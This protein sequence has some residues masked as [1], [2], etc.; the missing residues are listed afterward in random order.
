MGVGIPHNVLSAV[1]GKI[2]NTSENRTSTVTSGRRDAEMH[3]VSLSDNLAAPEGT[4]AALSVPVEVP[5]PNPLIEIW[6]TGLPNGLLGLPTDAEVS[7]RHE[8]VQHR[9]ETLFGPEVASVAQVLSVMASMPTPMPVVEAVAKPNPP[10]LAVRIAKPPAAPN[11][12][13]AAQQT[14]TGVMADQATV[15]ADASDRSA[16]SGQESD[17][18][19]NFL[20]QYDS[21]LTE[22]VA[23]RP[24]EGGASESSQAG[25]ARGALALAPGALAPPDVDS[26]LSS[27]LARNV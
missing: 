16:T 23:R 15:F 13:V 8:D 25:Q 12:S 10:M 19:S 3:T 21:R 22:G 6:S 17:F 14:K 24:E 18:L 9:V 20:E 5:T 27:F 11:A 26:L 2:T 4:A 7:K 1:K